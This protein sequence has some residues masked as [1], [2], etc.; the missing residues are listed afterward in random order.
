MA[1]RSDADASELSV[2][3]AIEQTD[4]WIRVSERRWLPKKCLVEVDTSKP[5]I[6][7][8]LCDVLKTS[9]VTEIDVSSCGLGPP[10]MEILSDYVRDATASVVTINC[11]ANEFGE[12]GLSTLLAAIKGTSVRSLCGLT[13]G[14]TVA[15]FSGQNL[16]PFDCKI[17]AAEFAFQGF[18][19][20]VNSITVDS[21]GDMPNYLSLIHI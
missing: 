19:A 4:D 9:S 5:C 11:L 20:S 1:D 18:I 14:Q 17:M 3:I 7:A 6:L 2:H 8:A 10:A 16:R 13:K 12:D 21:T 15:D